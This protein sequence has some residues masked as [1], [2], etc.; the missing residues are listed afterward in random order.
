VKDQIYTRIGKENWDSARGMVY[1]DSHLFIVADYIYKVDPNSGKSV[2]VSKEGGWSGTRNNT[3]RVYKGQ[4]LMALSGFLQG[5]I[6][7]FHV[8]TGN[9]KTVSDEDFR[10]WN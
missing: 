4:L 5:K 7:L 9:Y 8:K 1:M 6:V 2:K 3:V 10:V